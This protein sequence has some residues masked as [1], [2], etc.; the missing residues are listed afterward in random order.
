MPERASLGQRRVRA[1]ERPELGERFLVA[2][3]RR[4]LHAIEPLLDDREIGE[5]E[6]ELDH[7][8]IAHRI[9]RAHHVQHVVVV[10]R[11]HDVHD[12]VG[13]ADVREELVA[14]SFALRRALHESGDVD[15]LHRG[16][17]GPLRLHDARELVEPRVGHVHAADVRILRRER[18]VRG[19]HARPT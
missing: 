14:E 2:R 9:D 15:E 3:L 6:L 10:E 5:R 13:L 16:R 7:L 12:R 17:H 8:A 11:A 4:A 19:E 1:L 18:I